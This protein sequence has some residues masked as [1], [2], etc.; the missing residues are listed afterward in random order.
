MAIFFID[1]ELDLGILHG[2]SGGPQFS[3]DITRTRSGHEQRNSNRAVA[4]GMW[5]IGNVTLDRAQTDYLVE[6]FRSKKGMFLGFR[7]RDRSDDTLVDERIGFGDGATTLFQ[8]LRSYNTTTQVIEQRPI[9]KLDLLLPSNVKVD[10][11]LWANP[12]TLNPNTGIVDFLADPPP[13]A[14]TIT[15]SGTFHVPVRFGTDKLDL[16]LMAHR[17]EDNEVIYDLGSLRLIEVFS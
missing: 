13:N 14:S 6:F 16:T 15:V 5:E 8:V 11:V 4:G 7:F 1:E 9:K 10:N 17:D 12:Y 2:V 3:T